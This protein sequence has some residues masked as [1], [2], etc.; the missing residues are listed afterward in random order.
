MEKQRENLIAQTMKDEAAREIPAN[1]D[2][3]PAI[4]QRLQ[5]SSINKPEETQKVVT[6]VQP[7]P[8][9]ARNSNLRR[10]AMSGLVVAALLALFL[11]AISV[12]LINNEKGSFNNNLA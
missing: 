10:V 4:Q 11:V 3:W 8:F 12:L 6:S 9:R 5:Q 7:V 2:L 1:L